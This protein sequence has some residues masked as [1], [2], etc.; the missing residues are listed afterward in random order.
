MESLLG[1]RKGR[2]VLNE[3]PPLLGIRVLAKPLR[4][5][6]PLRQITIHEQSWEDTREHSLNLSTTT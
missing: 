1:V 4:E 2:K 6:E 3:T 5:V